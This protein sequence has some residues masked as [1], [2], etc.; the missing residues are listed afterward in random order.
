MVSDISLRDQEDENASDHTMMNDGAEGCPQMQLGYCIDTDAAFWGIPLSQT[1][2]ASREDE[3]YRYET[4][5]AACTATGVVSV[6]PDG[7]LV[8]SGFPSD[9]A[10]Q[11]ITDELVPQLVKY[12]V[13]A[14]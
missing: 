12:R 9:E 4:Y 1:R 8:F 2:C 7:R 11:A 3:V 6:Y 14:G 5:D 10:V 13:L